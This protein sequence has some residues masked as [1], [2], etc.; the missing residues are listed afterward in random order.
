[1]NKCQIVSDF[2]ILR[3]LYDFLFLINSY[4]LRLAF[5]MLGLNPGLPTHEANVLPLGHISSPVFKISL[6]HFWNKPEWA[7]QS[8]V[9]FWILSGNIF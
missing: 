9:E 2:S 7:I 6:L 5:V 1:M 3:W 8:T 4:E